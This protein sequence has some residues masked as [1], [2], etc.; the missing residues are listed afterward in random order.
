MNTFPEEAE[1]FRNGIL[2]WSRGTLRDFPWRE[3]ARNPYEILVAEMFLK[4][5][6]ASTVAD[7]YPAFIERY[8][9]P[10]S[11]QDASEAGIIEVI[12]P[13]GLYNH[14][15]KALKEIGETQGCSK[16][17]SSEEELVEFPQVAPYVANATLL[18]IW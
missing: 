4:Q 7:E 3:E 18:R 9:N 17:P 2:E 11:L 10:Y 5:T 6:R 1:R 13:L 12:R 16:I 8:T 14:R 15:A